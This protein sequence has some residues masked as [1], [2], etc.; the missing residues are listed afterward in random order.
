MQIISSEPQITMTEYGNGEETI[1]I[2]D[3]YINIDT[4]DISYKKL[5]SSYNNLYN[6]SSNE[7]ISYL[8]KYLL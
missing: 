6:N 7:P 2:E 8:N 3:N 1:D 5:I 4:K